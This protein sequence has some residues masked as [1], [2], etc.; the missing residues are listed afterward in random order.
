[1]TYGNFNIMVFPYIFALWRTKLSSTI[2]N[3]WENHDFKNAISHNLHML[4]IPFEILMDHQG[5]I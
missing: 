4:A 2:Q 1:M 3:V 5:F